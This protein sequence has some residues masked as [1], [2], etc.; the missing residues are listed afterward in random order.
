MRLLAAA[1][2][3]GEQLMWEFTS[4]SGG[5]SKAVATVAGHGRLR[6]RG[7]ELEQSNVV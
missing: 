7:L 2:V 5:G 3:M 6:R 4:G 1:A